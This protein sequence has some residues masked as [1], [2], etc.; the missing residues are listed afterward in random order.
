MLGILKALWSY[1]NFILSSVRN[2]VVTRFSRSALGGLWVILQPLA[3]VAIYALILSAVLSAKLPGIDNQYAYA[4]YLT[5]GMLAWSLFSEIITRC[6]NLFIEQSNLM[7]KMMF[8]RVT[9]PAIVVGSSLL[10]NGML[11]VAII[12]VFALLGHM[13]TMQIVWLPLITLFL[14][15]FS[16]GLG[17]TL[18]VLNVFIRD[19]GQ[20]VPIILQV[21][22]WFTP[23]VYPISIIPETYRDFLAY[24]PMYPIVKAYQ[25]ILVYGI[26]PDITAIGWLA[27]ISLLL[28][29]FGFF[30]FRRASPEMVDVL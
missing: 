11:F 25:D 5:A 24:N 12:G 1:K 13:P 30:L 27:L 6:L 9:L 20:V 18:G 16:M 8:P 28:L 19:I 2:E 17:L 26:M 15:A 3:Q 7:K 14:V 29:G 23:I 22:F 10:N 21:A 4:I